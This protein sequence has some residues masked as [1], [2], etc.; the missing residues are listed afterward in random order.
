MP[1]RT[2]T[3]AYFQFIEPMQRALNFVTV[4]RLLFG[5]PYGGPAAGSLIDTSF[6]NAEPAPLGGTRTGGPF[7]EGG[8]SLPDRSRAGHASPFPVQVDRLFLRFSGRRPPRDSG[9]PLELECDRNGTILSASAHRSLDQQ[10][11][12]DTSRSR[13][14]APYPDWSDSSQCFD[15]FCD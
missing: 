3:E 9:I 7:S 4:G 1:G 6:N 13:A 5:R 8:V 11:Q 10:W 12:H 15:T 2:P 14:Q